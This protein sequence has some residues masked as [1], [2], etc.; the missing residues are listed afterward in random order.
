M[1]YNNTDDMPL[2]L[3]VQD[4]ADTISISLANAYALCRSEGFPSVFINR[5]IMI[6]K[7]AFIKW[8]E[9]PSNYKNQ[10]V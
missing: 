7:L 4:I 10:G 9:N 3:T 6:P 8:M 2:F 5:R 1:K